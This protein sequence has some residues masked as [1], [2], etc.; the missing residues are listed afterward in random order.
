MRISPEIKQ[1]AFLATFALAMVV[2]GVIIAAGWGL[3]R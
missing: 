1:A 3:L 2:S